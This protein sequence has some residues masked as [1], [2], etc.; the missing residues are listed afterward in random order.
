M[1][2]NLLYSEV[3]DSLLDIGNICQ[4]LDL[5]ADYLFLQC[6]VCLQ[7]YFFVYLYFIW[8]IIY[9]LSDI[10]KMLHDSP[11]PKNQKQ[12]QNQKKSARSKHVFMPQ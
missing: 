6:W 8:N 7:I 3:K 10:K 11:P 1:E 2:L 12:Q 4:L 5:G 9:L